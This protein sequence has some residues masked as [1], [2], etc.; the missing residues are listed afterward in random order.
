M[1]T[2]HTKPWAAN[3]R[4]LLSAQQ[5]YGPSASA[6]LQCRQGRWAPVKTPKRNAPQ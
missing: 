3:L 4:A 2:P 1:H 6:S 5:R